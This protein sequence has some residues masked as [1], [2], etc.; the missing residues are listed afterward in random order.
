MAKS[1]SA[2]AETQQ[3]RAKNFA[4]PY[5]RLL[6]EGR[7]NITG[8]E[9]TGVKTSNV[10]FKPNQ[11]YFIRTSHNVHLSVVERHG[12]IDPTKKKLR[13]LDDNERRLAVINGVAKLTDVRELQQKE[14]Y[15]LFCAFNNLNPR[16][17]QSRRYFREE[18]W[19]ELLEPRLVWP[20]IYGLFFTDIKPFKNPVPLEIAPGAVNIVKVVRTKVLKQALNEVGLDW[21]A[22]R[23]QK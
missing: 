18:E 11:T 2:R 5:P 3:A 21:S 23:V 12:F 1:I 17:R 20:L 8:E 4:Y 15:E 19:P 6:M 14:Q 13:E 22:M 16:S 9:N 10:T 7:L